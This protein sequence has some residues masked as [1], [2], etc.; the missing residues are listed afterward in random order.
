MG[1]RTDNAFVCGVI[2]RFH[3]RFAG[4]KKQDRQCAAWCSIDCV[5]KLD[6][7][8]FLYVYRTVFCGCG[9]YDCSGGISEH[10]THTGGCILLLC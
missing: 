5:S 4:N 10:K 2:C 3:G 6:Q 9:F 1:E 8:V 7:F